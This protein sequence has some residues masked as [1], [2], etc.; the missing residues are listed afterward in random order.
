MPNTL[1]P[2]IKTK[3]GRQIWAWC[4]YDFANSAYGVL[5]L[6]FLFPVYYRE[7]LAGGGGRGDLWW[8]LAFGGSVGLAALLS[9]LIGR[10]ADRYGLRLQ[11]L[12]LLT[13]I[14]IG[15]TAFLSIGPT[16]G[17]ITC[18]TL[19]I[20]TNL[21]YTLSGTLYDS[22]LPEV[23]T[24]KQR[25]FV[26]GLGWSLGY[27]GGIVVSLAF[28]PLYRAGFATDLNSYLLCFALIGAFF[29]VFA[30]PSSFLLPRI[31]P[32]PA[33]NQ[34]NIIKDLKAT[35]SLRQKY[36]DSFILILG[37]G[38]SYVALSTIFSFFTIYSN[39]T[40][41]A[42]VAEVTYLFL[43]FQIVGFPATL[44]AG[45]LGSR[46]G[47]LKILILTLIGWILILVALLTS[48]PLPVAYAISAFCGLLSGPGQA[49]A[50]T[51]ASHLFPASQRGEF[52]GFFSLSAR[53]AGSLGPAL[54]GLISWL[55]GSQQVA[56]SLNII[57]LVLG[58]SVLRKLKL[59][60]P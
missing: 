11:L 10:G 42:S 50:R 7:L 33:L 51:L 5:F 34:Q 57:F 18:T 23:T 13:L 38:L 20:I 1:V 12:R 46:F 15:G 3:E 47:E 37:F 28:L 54:F 25:A 43:I 8:G 17:L 40:L 16:L 30:L 9:P 29:L 14:C 19:L 59:P 36:P 6:T 48:P 39:V 26:S 58:I 45:I 56:L 49:S 41:K 22:Y 44:L 53:I 31:P 4:L 35:L 27:V 24:P 55:S 52:F 2:S 32:S 21:G 60:H